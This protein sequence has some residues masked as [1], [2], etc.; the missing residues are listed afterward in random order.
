MKKF[1]YTN[2]NFQKINTMLSVIGLLVIG[3]SF[4]T[5]QN[6]GYI[7]IIILG[8]QQLIFSFNYSRMQRRGESTVSLAIAMFMFVCAAIMKMG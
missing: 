2:K 1:N 3:F 8:L 5:S 7:I 6:I 4:Y